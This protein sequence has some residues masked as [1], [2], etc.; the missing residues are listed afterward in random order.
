MIIVGG[1]GAPSFLFDSHP[2]PPLFRQAHLLRF[3]NIAELCRELAARLPYSESE[4]VDEMSSMINMWEAQEIRLTEHDTREAVPS[5]AAHPPSIEYTRSIGGF[6]ICGSSRT[7]WQVTEADLDAFCGCW[8]DHE[9]DLVFIDRDY[10]VTLGED[11]RP[12]LRLA[13]DSGFTVIDRSD[14]ARHRTA[15]SFISLWGVFSASKDVM[16]VLA[17]VA[18]ANDGS[19]D[20]VE[21][22][23]SIS[24]MPRSGGLEVASSCCLRTTCAGRT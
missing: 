24:Q 16:H 12:S 7:D 23:C 5:T 1:H 19:I 9:G 4:G 2:R 10:A 14:Q 8:R 11:D 18:F 15:T 22:D 17:T 13:F 6:S 20:A 3:G 21:W